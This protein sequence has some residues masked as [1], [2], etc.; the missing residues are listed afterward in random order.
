MVSRELEHVYTDADPSAARVNP[1]NAGVGTQNLNNKYNDYSTKAGTVDGFYP[2]RYYVWT[3]TVADGVVTPADTFTL[4]EIL[5]ST[6]TY[7]GGRPD[8]GDIPRVRWLFMAELGYE[9]RLKCRRGSD[10]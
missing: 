5:S 8:N 7:T 9:N 10:S 1:Y 4:V 2:A 3:D 6:P